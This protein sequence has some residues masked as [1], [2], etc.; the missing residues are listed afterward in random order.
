MVGDT[1]HTWEELKQ[2]G[3]GGGVKMKMEKLQAD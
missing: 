2:L 3:G 1:L